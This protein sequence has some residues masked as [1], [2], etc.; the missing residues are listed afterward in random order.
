LNF[1]E[2][3]PDAPSVILQGG[4]ERGARGRGGRER[5]GGGWESGTE[6]VTEK[7]LRIDD[8]GRGKAREL[9]EG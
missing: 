8:G 5:R 7:P 4:A 6:L 9:D 2:T 3:N 1:E